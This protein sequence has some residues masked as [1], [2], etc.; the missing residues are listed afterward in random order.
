ML[1]II[2][3]GCFGQMG[4]VVQ[5]AINDLPD[6]T[7]IAG[8][9]RQKQTADFPVYPN[10]AAVKEAGDVI[11]DFSHENSL[12]ALLTQL[13]NKKIPLVCATTGLSEK[14]QQA[15]QTASQSL[16]IFYSANMSLGINVLIEALQKIT[17]ALEADFNIEIVEKHH[18]R[19]KDAPSGTALLLA[20][21]INEVCHSKKEYIY[22]RSGNENKNNLGQMGIHAVRGGT[23][24]GE[25]TVIY[26]GNGEIL[27]LKHTALSRE[28]FANGALQAARFIEQQKAGMYTMHDLLN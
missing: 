12:T 1:R 9:D 27:E 10:L 6:T 16:P 17:P 5:Q 15:L 25:H 22:G 3:N 13:T 14:T 11:I 18:R 8:I 4:K 7:L 19:K 24:P 21:R 23:I 26:A 20:D 2:L 28:I